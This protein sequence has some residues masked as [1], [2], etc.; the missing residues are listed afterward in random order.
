[1][2]YIRGH[3]FDSVEYERHIVGKGTLIM[4]IPPANEGEPKK[5]RDIKDET[6]IPVPARHEIKVIDGLVKMA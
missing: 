5:Y 2:E 1:V 3:I 6:A 4:I